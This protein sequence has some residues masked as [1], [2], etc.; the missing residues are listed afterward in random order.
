MAAGPSSGPD[1]GRSERR[2][3]SCGSDVDIAMFRNNTWSGGGSLELPDGRKF[4]ATTNF[5]QTSFELKTEA[6][7]TLVRFKTRGLLH[8][9]ATVEIQPDAAAMPELP[10]LV[11]F[12]WYLVVM[13]HM[14]SAALTG[15]VAATS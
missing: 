5:W 12:G 13:M 4:L 14:D 3:R 10:W 8:L 7:E 15:S 6:D 1:S 2:F 9:S 11:M